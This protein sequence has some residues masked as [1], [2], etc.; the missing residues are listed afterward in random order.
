MAV[1]LPVEAQL[2]VPV[3]L[4]AVVD[5]AVLGADLPL[6][7][8]LD[9]LLDRRPRVGRDLDAPDRRTR[10]QALELDGLRLGRDDREPPMSSTA[11]RDE[12]E[13][14]RREAEAMARADEEEEAAAAAAERR[15][16]DDDGMKICAH[17]FEPQVAAAVDRMALACDFCAQDVPVS[18]VY[19]HCGTRHVT[20]EFEREGGCDICAACY[21]AQKHLTGGAAT[22]ARRQARRA[23]EGM[24]S[25]SRLP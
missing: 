18:Q 21:A 3:A 25:T 12:E 15:A 8:E 20:H 16:Q 10:R 7:G 9:A 19:W 4:E 5:E 11:R 17:E 23:E 22:R 24:P 13:R 6:V 1:G 14:M 2:D